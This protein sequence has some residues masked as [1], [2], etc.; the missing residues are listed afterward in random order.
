M[1]HNPWLKRKGMS[2]EKARTNQYP[3]HLTNFSFSAD[4]TTIRNPR[5]LWTNNP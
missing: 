1:I 4:I 5:E 2:Q 3:Q